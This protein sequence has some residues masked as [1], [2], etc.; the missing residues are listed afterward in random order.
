M[1]RAE[2]QIA[3]EQGQFMR[4]LVTAIGATRTLEIGVFTGYSAA[5]TALALPPGGRVVACEVNGEYARIAERWWEEAGVAGKIDLRIGPALET[6]DTLLAD[7][8][9]D[10]FDFA[11][12]DAAKEQ[13]VEYWERCLR[14]VRPG[15][16]I[17]V[18][19]VLWGGRVADPENEEASTAAI[20]V[21]NAHVR[22]DDRVDLSLVPIG[23]G[24]T[25]ARVR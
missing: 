5:A 24:V 10:A 3:P 19:N 22:E 8:E 2:M 17:A 15:G 21:F 7:G 4:L 25:L 1:E 11:F 13:Y 16:L 6:L 23:D 14:L 18:D 20:R 12:I 9:D